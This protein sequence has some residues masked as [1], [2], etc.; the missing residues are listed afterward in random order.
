MSPPAVVS[1][2]SLFSS[3]ID[4]LE[5]AHRTRSARQSAGRDELGETVREIA[6]SYK[7]RRASPKTSPRSGSRSRRARALNTWARS[8]GLMF[9][10]KLTA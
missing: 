2:C 10:A 8:T 4:N 3:G 1:S 5:P 9:S 6:R 7:V